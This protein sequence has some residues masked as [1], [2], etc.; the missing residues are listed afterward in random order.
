MNA[1]SCADVA[2]ALGSA[3]SW[4]QSPSTPI[5]EEIVGVRDG[6]SVSGIE[7]ILAVVAGGPAVKVSFS[8]D[9]PAKLTHEE[10]VSPYYFLGDGPD[11]RPIGW[12]TRSVPDGDYTLTVTPHGAAGPGPSRQAKFKVK[13]WIVFDGFNRDDSAEMGPLWKAG[14]GWSIVNGRLYTGLGGYSLT[15]SMESYPQ[16]DYVIETRIQGVVGGNGFLSDIIFLTFGGAPYDSD[17]RVRRISFGGNWDIARFDRLPNGETQYIRLAFAPIPDLTAE[18]E[19][20]IKLIHANNG[21]MQ[22]FV[23]KSN[24]PSYGAALLDVVDTTYPSL[25]HFGWGVER[26]APGTFFIDF[27]GAR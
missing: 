9:G 7:A 16:R 1:S 2:L 21:R 18:D 17:Y 24:Q 26:E 19:L 27:I 14:F 10:G 22:L 8:L 6:E 4:A 5:I 15:Q 20:D 12:D 11:G 25:G 13:N 23:K 3:V